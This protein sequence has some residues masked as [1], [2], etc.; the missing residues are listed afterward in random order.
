MTGKGHRVGTDPVDVERWE[1]QRR[2][3]LDALV[4]ALAA[5]DVDLDSDPLGFLPVLDQFVAGQDFAGFDQD[6]WLWLHTAL[7][8]YLA[9][10]LIV[11]HHARW[12]TT[13]DERGV[14][15]LLVMTGLDGHEHAVSP[16]DVV[17]DDFQHLPPVVMR[18]LATAER[19]AH[20][21]PDPH[22]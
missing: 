15:Y 8:A 9:Q 19:T 18:M 22:G 5:T 21:V 20:V 12:D 14:N 1:R 6:D 3:A 11:V 4:Q 17:Y 10:V 16:M 7:G 13:T 2:Q